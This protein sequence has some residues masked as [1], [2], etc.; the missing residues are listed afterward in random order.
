MIYFRVSD[1][2]SAEFSSVPC[3]QRGVPLGASSGEFL[4]LKGHLNSSQRLWEE[5]LVYLGEIISGPFFS[6]ILRVSMAEH[7]CWFLRHHVGGEWRR[8][9]M[10]FRDRRMDVCG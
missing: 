1:A 7:G 4:G 9:G 5:C 2:K 10:A 6:Y 8:V 3:F